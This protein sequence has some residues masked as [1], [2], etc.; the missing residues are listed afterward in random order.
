L[1]DKRFL[2]I[3]DLTHEKPPQWL[4]KGLFEANSLVMLAGPAGSYKSF[5][6]TD[7]LMSMATGR[8]WQ[9][10]DTIPSKVLYSLG[11][12]KSN[13]LKRLKANLHYHRHLNRN[14]EPTDEIKDLLN[15][16]FRVSFEVPQLAMKASVDNMLAGLEQERFHPSVIVIDTFARSFV[17]LDENS[18][19][20]TG[21]WIEQADRL[22]QLG[23]TVIFLHHTAKNSE[24]GVKYRGSTAIMG[25]MDTAFT[26]VKDGP[27]SDRV[28]VSMSKQKDHEEAKPLTFQRQQIVAPGEVEDSIVLIPTVPKDDRFTD[29]NM[30]IEAAIKELLQTPFESDRA[31]ART[32][33]N[34]F[35][36]SEG[37]AQSRIIRYKNERKED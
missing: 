13:L 30:R 10:R 8:N 23:F 17:G 16:N 2:T 14:G 6:V 35:G 21:L 11:E 4:I 18:Q 3:E 9:D 28:T 19:K 22:R 1:A 34:Q 20:D 26:M 27:N 31:R 12:G 33:A 15:S 24:L 5:L 37:A 32:L 36:L 29:D 7:W 25:A